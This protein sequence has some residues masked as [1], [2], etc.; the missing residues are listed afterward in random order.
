MTDTTCPVCGQPP[1][2][3]GVIQLC[4][5]EDCG[6]F[7]LLREKGALEEKEESKEPD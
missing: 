5:R 1:D 2:I 3:P 6:A 7:Q 4:G